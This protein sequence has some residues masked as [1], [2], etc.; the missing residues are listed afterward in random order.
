MDIAKSSGAKIPALE[1]V[2]RHLQGAKNYAGPKADMTAVY[3]AVR[4][5]SGL[6]YES[7]PQDKGKAKAE[8]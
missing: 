2:D 4:L 7:D 8:S 6:P 1:M 5:D 3:G